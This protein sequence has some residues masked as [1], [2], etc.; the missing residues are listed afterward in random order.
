MGRI[1]LNHVSLTFRVRQQKEKNSLKDMMLRRILGRP[2][3]PMVEV[4]ALQDV[5]LSVRGGERLGILGHNG[6]GKSTLLKLLAGIYP[7]TSGRRRVVGQISSLFDISLGFEGDSTGWENIYYRSFLQGETPRSVN[8]KIKEIA[9]FT[10]LGDY[11]HIPVRYYSAGMMVRLAFSIAT[12]VKPEILLIDEV[13]GVGDQ[14]FQ[15]KARQR[16][17]EMMA[18]AELIVVVSHDLHSLVRMCDRGL[19]MQQG[20]VLADGPITEVADRYTL[21][22]SEPA[23]G[24]APCR[25][26]AGRCRCLSCQAFPRCLFCSSRLDASCL[27]VR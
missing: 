22:A 26:G 25:Y 1:E 3:N 10:E 5:S 20:R 19:W 2:V 6:A 17:N 16:M 13:L 24:N 23:R 21:A 18:Q 9:D 4:R 27:F 14:A 12:A 8:A 7:P 11:L 15:D